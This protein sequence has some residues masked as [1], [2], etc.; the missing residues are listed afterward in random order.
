MDMDNVWSIAG[1]EIKTGEKKQVYVQVCLLYTSHLRINLI[2][3][4]TFADR[5]CIHT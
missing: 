5:I 4:T 3:V 2:I 1:H